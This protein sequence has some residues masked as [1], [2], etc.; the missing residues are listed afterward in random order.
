MK[1][2]TTAIIILT[3]FLSSFTLKNETGK[4]IA[5]NGKVTFFSHTDMEDI[6]AE[7][8]KVSSILDSKT[9]KLAIEILIKSFHFKKAM[10]EEHFNENYMESDKFSKSKFDGKIDNIADVDFSKNGTYN[11]TISGNL[12]IK[13]KTNKISTKGTLKVEGQ[14]VGGKAVFKILLSDY[15]ISI[16][17]MVKEKISNEIEI[18]ADIDYQS[19]K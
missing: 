12:T 9:G 7:N 5:K 3:V 14:K 1:F 10:M 2:K 16:P 6:T 13:D 18:T 8:N 19:M 11:V 4:Y 17:A 15:G